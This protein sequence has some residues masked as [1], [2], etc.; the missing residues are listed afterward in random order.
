MANVRGLCRLRRNGRTAEA[1]D[2]ALA[3][4]APSPPY[5]VRA[6]QFLCASSKHKKVIAF[7]PSRGASARDLFVVVRG[8]DVRT[9][10]P[11]IVRA[12]EASP[13]VESVH[14]TPESVFGELGAAQRSAP[15][16]FVAPELIDR[17]DARLTPAGR[18]AAIA[19]LRAKLASDPV[20]GRELAVRDPLGLRWILD[21]AARGVSPL[22]LA[23]GTPYA[24]LADGRTALIRVH[25]LLPSLDV[26]FSRALL[27][28]LERVAEQRT[29]GARS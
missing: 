29:R 4:A 7:L 5:C 13:H 21:D 17:L 14:A 9:R 16:A 10:I 6:S 2:K 11:A 19:E 20:G 26:A 18:Q 8:D 24:V 25:G 1:E 12:L 15:L 3:I 23:R 22:E 28:D 27:A